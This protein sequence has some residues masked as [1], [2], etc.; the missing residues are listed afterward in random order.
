MT[1][2]FHR[3]PRLYKIRKIVSTSVSEESN[4]QNLVNKSDGVYGITIPAHIAENYKDVFFTIIQ[5]ETRIILGSCNPEVMNSKH[6]Q[7]M[8]NWNKV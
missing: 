4:S 2:S 3:K 7:F 6:F 1:V 8:Y 5:E